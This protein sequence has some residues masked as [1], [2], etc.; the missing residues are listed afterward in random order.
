MKYRPDSTWFVNPSVMTQDFIS[1]FNR[2]VYSH[3]RGKPAIKLHH[4]KYFGRYAPAWKTIEYMTMG[5][6]EVLYEKLI[7]NTDKR[8]ISIRFNEPAISAFKTY[9][10]AIREVRNA[11]AHG[12]VLYGLRLSSGIITGAACPSFAPGSNQTFNGALRVIDYLLRQISVNRAKEM[13]SDLYKV[14]ARLGK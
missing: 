11:C 4:N 3:L 8:L 12:N 2:E 6:L 5:N 7:L 13:W 1:G 10:T 9:L 14:T